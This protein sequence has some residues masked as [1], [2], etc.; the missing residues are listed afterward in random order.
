MRIVLMGPPG[1]GKG[2]QAK[3]MRE[4]TGMAHIST[5]DLLRKAV[6]SQT[7]IG[8]AAQDYMD[9]GELVPDRLV[10]GMIDHRLQAEGG[11]RSFMLDGFPRTVGQ[12]E[13]LEGMLAN[14][15]IPLHHVISLAVSRE[16]L[17]RRLSG[18]RTCR[19]CNA[20]FH[21]AFDPPRQADVCDRCGGALYQ[22]EDDREDTIRARLDVYDRSTAPLAT[23]YRS[24]GLLREIDGTGATAD[25]LDRVLVRLEA[26][27]AA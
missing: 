27:R 9:R 15:E 13:A 17:V 4:R 8:R 19:Q 6:A 1:A 25:V 26:G 18:R 7:E 2:T 16:E 3:L 10:I 11:V 22:R 20:M 24:R 21:V 14:G 12:A 23:F 5:G